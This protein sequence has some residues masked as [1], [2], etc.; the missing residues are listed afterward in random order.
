MVRFIG[1]DQW[2]DIVEAEAKEQ[3][4]DVVGLTG[5]EQ[6]ARPDVMP[7]DVF[8]QDLRRVQLGL[9]GDRI[10][11]DV[12]AHALAQHLLHEPQV[13]RRGRAGPCA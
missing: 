10:H 6:P 13:R 12:A 9:Q 1:V 2:V 11:E 4:L 3:F 5:Q 8:L 7:L